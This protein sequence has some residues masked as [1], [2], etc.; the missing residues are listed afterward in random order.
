MAALTIRRAGTVYSLSQLEAEYPTA[1]EALPLAPA[2]GF[3]SAPDEAV[4]NIQGALL[5]LY[6]YPAPAHGGG[7]GG[8]GFGSVKLRVRSFGDLAAAAASAAAVP[9]VDDAR[10]V[11]ASAL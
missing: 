7:G 8:S 1:S 2:K 10:C 9:D 5:P 6:R 11:P 3:L 4:R